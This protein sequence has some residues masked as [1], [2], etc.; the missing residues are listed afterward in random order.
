MS[1]EKEVPFV[2]ATN[3]FAEEDAKRDELKKS[4]NV[5]DQ[6]TAVLMEPHTN[7]TFTERND[8]FG[9][10]YSFARPKA[11]IILEKFDVKLKEIN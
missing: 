1:K 9:L 11:A 6:L 7:E 4:S 2:P 3:L 5:L 8:A 10:W